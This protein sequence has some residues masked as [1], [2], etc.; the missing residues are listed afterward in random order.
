MDT[1]QKCSP[2]KK[3]LGAKIANFPPDFRRFFKKE[4]KKG[5]RAENRNFTVKF[6]TKKKKGHDLGPFLMSRKI[7][8]SLAEDRAF[9]RAWKLQGQG[10]DMRDQGLQNVS[11]RTPPLVESICRFRF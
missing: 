5:L 2:K 7:G 8:L 11:S 3:G 1:T 6:Q 10:L 4:K 9:L